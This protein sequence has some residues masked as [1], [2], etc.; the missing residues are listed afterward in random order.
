MKLLCESCKLFNEKIKLNQGLRR[1]KNLTLTVK[2][3]IN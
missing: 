1:R 2:K 3:K